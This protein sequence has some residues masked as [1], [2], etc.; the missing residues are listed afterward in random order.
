MTLNQVARG[1]AQNWRPWVAIVSKELGVSP[2][3]TLKA[4]FHEDTE[5]L[6]ALDLPLSAVDPSIDP[7]AM[8][9]PAQFPVG[10]LESSVVV[11]PLV[12]EPTISPVHEGRVA[13]VRHLLRRN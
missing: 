3:T 1:Y 12:E 13:R 11:P 9:I 5:E 2:S 4:Y 10:L 8:V 7:P 6:P